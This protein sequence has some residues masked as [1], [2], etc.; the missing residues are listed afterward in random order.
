MLRMK[1]QLADLKNELDAGHPSTGAYS[2]DHQTAA[3]EL[4]T[5][6][7]VGPRRV[8]YL[9]M[10]NELDLDIVRRLI[11]TVDA[12]APS[13][14]VV[15]EIK[16]YLR[17]SDGVDVGN[18]KTRAMLDAFAANGSLP[19]TTDDATAIKAL[20]PQISRA[21]QLGWGAVQEVDVRHARTL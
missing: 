18:P 15:G 3:D 10:M 19:L 4:N 2:D 17:G 9:T 6:Y 7:T 1:M 21:Q 8:A 5:P 13:D 16:H 11:A 20:A 12:V 14:P